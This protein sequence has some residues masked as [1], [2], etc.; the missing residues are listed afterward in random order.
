MVG[1]TRLSTSKTKSPVKTKKEEGEDAAP[2]T[3]GV[4]SPRS[5]RAT[6]RKAK[7]EDDTA[8]KVEVDQ[9]SSPTANFENSR[10]ANIARN[11]A[12]LS[13]LG[14]NSA[15]A[16]LSSRA[17]PKQ[18]PAHKKKKKKPITAK[19]A[20]KKEEL[21]PRRTS[22]RLLRIPADSEVAKRK[23]EDEAAAIAQEAR[24]KRQRVEGDLKLGDIGVRD[25]MV[26]GPLV[27]LVGRGAKP[28][29][30]TFTARDVEETTDKA[31]KGLRERM[32]SLEIYQGWEVND[33]KITPERIYSMGFHPTPFKPLIFAGDKLG[34]LGI[35]DASQTGPEQADDE[36]E[37]IPGPEISQYHMHARTISALAFSSDTLY[38]ASYD[39]T[40]R[41]LPLSSSTSTTIFSPGKDNIDEDAPI[42]GISLP[43]EQQL[44]ASTLHGA[45]F[46]HDL[47][48]AA[49]SSGTTMFALSDKKIGGFSH[50]PEMPHLIATASLDRTLRVW[51]L[52]YVSGRGDGRLPHL[53]GEHESR[54]S[55]SHAAFNSVGQI[56]TSS[57]DDTVKIHRCPEES[58]LSGKGDPLELGP[59]TIIKHN[60]QTGRWVTILRAMWQQMPSDGH[61]KFVIGNMNRFVD[62]YDGRGEQ[63]AQLGGGVDGIT[64]VP[65]VA[66]WHPG[67]NWVGAG[68]ASG[69][70]CHWS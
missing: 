68:T 2:E 3:N 36:D 32:S 59:E 31:L 53:V 17:P 22:S 51:D 7:S 64:A 45:F 15:S 25:G 19:V 54:L 30:R 4:K 56:A 43:S 27:D 5:T 6:P 46:S 47:R 24:K 1:R 48:T 55:V 12:L 67:E 58:T 37:D 8:V 35:F 39:S 40:I 62:I 28:G 20:V 41:S 69:K 9:P 11:R 29:N 50:H 33:I 70:L 16:A 57:Y 49:H 26:S 21:V 14:V 38:T 65:A 23:A 34:N 63:L 60:N 66:V 18:D 52:R 42:S 13:S 44:Y 10:A 61:Q